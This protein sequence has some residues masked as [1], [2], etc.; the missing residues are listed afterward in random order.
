M[1][2]QRAEF[3]VRAFDVSF[4]ANSGHFRKPPPRPVLLRK[5]ASIRHP[6]ARTYRARLRAAFI[7]PEMNRRC[8]AAST[9]R[10]GRLFQT[11][12]PQAE[13]APDAPLFDL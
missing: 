11:L 3:P 4:L 5:P 12:H 1:L 6:S 9:V 8:A 2:D 7:R 10:A 13:A